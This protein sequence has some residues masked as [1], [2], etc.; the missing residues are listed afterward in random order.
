MDALYVNPLSV[1]A[2][3]AL[4]GAEEIDVPVDH[5]LEPEWERRP[6]FVALSPEARLPVLVIAGG[7]ILSG[8]VPIL[9]YW[10]EQS[11]RFDLMGHTP[12]A[13]AEVRRLMQWFLVRFDEEVARPLGEEKVLKRLVHKSMPDTKIL[14]AVQHNLRIHVQYVE[15]LSQRRHYLAG[16]ALS[17]ADVAA[18]AAMSLA[19][20]M[21]DI[22]WA[23]H[24]AAKDWYM[25]MKSRRSVRHCLAQRISGVTPPKHY[26]LPDF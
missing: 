25:R 13:R 21:G 19:D 20:Y 14:R 6:E 8:A 22:P 16:D 10:S 9:E 7:H 15:Y 23:D 5:R 26:A 18:A 24:L 11:D 17:W 12:L 3:A 4:I 2:R 1:P